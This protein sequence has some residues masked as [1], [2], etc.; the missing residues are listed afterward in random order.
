MSA[1]GEIGTTTVPRAAAWLG[2]FGLLPF[3]AGTLL[4]LA[5]DLTWPADALRFYA[6]C[7]LAFMGGIHW[8]LGI[9]D[10]GAPS[11]QGASWSRL[12]ASVVPALIAWMA[13]LLPDAAGLLVMAGAFALLLAGDLLA[14]REG[15]APVWYPRLRVPL[16]AIVVLCLLLALMG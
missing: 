12:G 16:T 4:V 15:L 6:A 1:S 10:A 9:A 2:G 5:A 3:V 13:L 14:V 7:I 11:G 8:G